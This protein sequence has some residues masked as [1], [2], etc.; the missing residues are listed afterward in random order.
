MNYIDGIDMG[1]DTAESQDAMAADH[2]IALDVLYRRNNRPVRLIAR[3]S[4]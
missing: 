3:L 4:G 2:Q 1:F